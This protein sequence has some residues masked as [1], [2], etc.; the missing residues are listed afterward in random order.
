MILNC[1]NSLAGK[2]IFIDAAD[3]GEKCVQ[4]STKYFTV[5]NDCDQRPEKS[6]QIDITT[7][8]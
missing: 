1:V 6:N 2:G 7:K 8:L 5:S 4:F 3:D